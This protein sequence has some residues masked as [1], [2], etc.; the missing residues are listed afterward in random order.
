M[1]PWG[2]LIRLG[3]TIVSFVGTIVGGLAAH[4]HLANGLRMGTWVILV[5]AAF[6]TACVTAGGNVLNDTL[7]READRINHPDRPL[8]TGAIQVSHAKA[9]IV[10]LFATSIVLILPIV[11]SAW[12]LA[13]ILAVAWGALL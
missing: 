1:R 4:G 3:N 9:L 2:K 7:D 10:I 11:A 13:L 12:L 6:S 5:L 8:V